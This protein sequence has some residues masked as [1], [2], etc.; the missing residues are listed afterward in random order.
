MIRELH[1]QCYIRCQIDRTLRLSIVYLRQGAS[2][3]A[4][5]AEDKDF[6]RFVAAQLQCFLYQRNV[7]HPST[8]LDPKRCRNQQFGLEK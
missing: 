8:W 1:S 5:S 3:H 2:H 6:V 7:V 4:G